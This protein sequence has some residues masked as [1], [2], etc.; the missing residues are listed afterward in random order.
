MTARRPDPMICPR[1]PFEDH[2]RLSHDDLQRALGIAQSSGG[3]FAEVFLEYR[4]YS[5][6]LMEEDIIKETAESISLGPGLP[7]DGLRYAV[8][9]AFRDRHPP[10]YQPLGV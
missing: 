10:D 4:A 8:G 5:F 9:A 2:F 3:R 1:L 7:A 6:V